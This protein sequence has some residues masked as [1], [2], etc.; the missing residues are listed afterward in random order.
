MYPTGYSVSN[1]SIGFVYLRGVEIE[2]KRASSGWGVPGIRG[3]TV[4]STKVPT[5]SFSLHSISDV[6]SFRK[7]KASV[8]LTETTKKD[9]LYL[10]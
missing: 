3:S 8:T 9:A 7:M 6:P 5:V 2:W 10:R 1:A 4:Q